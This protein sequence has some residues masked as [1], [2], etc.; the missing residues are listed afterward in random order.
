MCAGSS[1]LRTA[2]ESLKWLP[3]NSSRRKLVIWVG[4]GNSTSSKKCCDSDATGFTPVVPWGLLLGLT[5]RG[6]KRWNQNGG[7]KEEEKESE[8]NKSKGSSL[9]KN[10]TSTLYLSLIHI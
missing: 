8:E 3:R 5:G 1:L 7:K 10:L 9:P 6:E 4:P 2:K